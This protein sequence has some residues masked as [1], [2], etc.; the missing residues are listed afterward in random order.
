MVKSAEEDVLM[1]FF[2]PFLQPKMQSI[3]IDHSCHSGGQCNSMNK[4]VKNRTLSA[5]AG[6]SEC[7]SKEKNYTN[8][9][10]KNQ[11]KFRK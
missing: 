4:W 10:Q 11:N 1:L 2:A 3:W 5:C 7:D 9:R 8:T 6:T